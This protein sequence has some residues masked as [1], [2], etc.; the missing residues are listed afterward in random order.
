[1]RIL[2]ISDIH[3]YVDVMRLIFE[4][5]QEIEIVVFSGDIAPYHAPFKTRELIEKIIDLAKI[6][7]IELFIAVPGNVDIPEEYNKVVDNLFINLHNKFLEYREYVFIGLGGS[8]ITPFKTRFEMS[9]EE[10][11][12]NLL[13]IYANVRNLK[14]KLE[15]MILVT[16]SPPYKT[17]CDRIYTGENVGSK[18]IRKFVEIVK[19]VV[20]FC[21]HVHESRC[22]DTI[23]TTTIVNPGPLSKG[24]YSIVE[25]NSLNVKAYHKSIK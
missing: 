19:P 5:E 11:E 23:E 14:N 9:E 25:I 22:I 21:G 12:K 18:A 7:R 6:Y 1:M 13:D 4:K 10:I 24:F 17:K 15:K 3:G 16:H 20:V 2:A 8:T